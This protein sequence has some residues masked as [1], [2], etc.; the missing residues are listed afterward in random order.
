MPLWGE[1][2]EDEFEDTHHHHHR[3]STLRQSLL[4]V[5]STWEAERDREQHQS[6]IALQGARKATAEANQR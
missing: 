4:N 6:R 5:A 1:D 2:Y 3:A